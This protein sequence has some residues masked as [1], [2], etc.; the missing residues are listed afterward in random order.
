[1][2]NKKSL[3]VLKVLSSICEDGTYKVIEYEN[4]IQKLSIEKNSSKMVIDQIL[5]NLKVCQY[6]DI[7]Y[8]E[9]NTYC[10]SVLPKGRMIIEE[11]SMFLKSQKTTN[12]MLFATMLFS[13]IMA[14]IGAFLA[15]ILFK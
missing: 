4:L 15:V 9:N 14:F 3:K 11:K 12:L 6:I 7:K 8:A 10:L 2:L 1:M 13:G 5:D